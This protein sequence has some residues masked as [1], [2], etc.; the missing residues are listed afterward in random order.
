MLRRFLREES[1]ETGVA[2]ALTALVVAI[3]CIAALE[4]FVSR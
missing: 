2:Y 1:G 4:A 3:A